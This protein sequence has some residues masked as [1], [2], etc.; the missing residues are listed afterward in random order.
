MVADTVEDR[1]CVFLAGL[2]RAEQ[3]IAERLRAL[4][5]GRPPWPAIDADKAIPW[6]EA[7]DRAGAWPPASRQALRLALRPRC[8]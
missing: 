8:W 4:A 3:A 1:R 5:A 6:V 2:Y 7:Q